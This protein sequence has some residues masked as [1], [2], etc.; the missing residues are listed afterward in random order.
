MLARARAVGVL[1]SLATNTAF[2]AILALSA[3]V[4]SNY[5][6]S[7]AIEIQLVSP[8]LPRALLKVQAKKLSERDRRFPTT[9]PQRPGSVASHSAEI[10]TPP[11]TAEVAP[12]P[13][14]PAS[15]VGEHRDA[16]VGSA[17]R[18]SIGCAHASFLGLSD[19][20]KLRCQQRMVERSRDAPATE[21]GINP[22]ARAEFDMA[23]N[24]DH[25][26]QHLAYLE[27]KARFGSGQFSW[28]RPYRRVRLGPSP[29]YLTTPEAIALPDRPK[30]KGF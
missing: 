6:P 2:L 16:G 27:C 30:P 19:A 25:T 22:E 24:D 18:A 5:G 4:Q 11:E 20:E 1:A 29:C 14:S 3:R 26:P 13:V 23:W 17:L 7:R 10:Q 9:A 12:Q 8:T 15:A 28:Q 21:I